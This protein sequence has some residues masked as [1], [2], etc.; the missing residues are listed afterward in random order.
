[1]ALFF[2]DR[3]AL[4]EMSCGPNGKLMAGSMH[5]VFLCEEVLFLV[6]RMRL[7]GFNRNHHSIFHAVRYHRPLPGRRLRYLRCSCI[8]HKGWLRRSP[9]RLRARA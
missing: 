7:E 1:M 3:S 9:V 8:R 6:L 4:T 5:F 2:A